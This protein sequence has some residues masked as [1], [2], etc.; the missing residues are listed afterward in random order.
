MTPR[1]L[2]IAVLI[3]GFVPYTSQDGAQAGTDNVAVTYQVGWWAYQENLKINAIEVELA[4]DKS[5]SLMNNKTNAKIIIRGV[6]SGLEGNWRPTI[7]RIHASERFT[8]SAESKERVSRIELTPI[9]E[10]VKDSSYKGSDVPFEISFTHPV[11]TFR[12]GNNDMVFVSGNQE[13]KIVLLQR[14]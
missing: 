14:K 2:V 1:F 13:K 9:V 3:L 5:L 8:P 10:V 12:W 7:A 4:G 6:V 11:N